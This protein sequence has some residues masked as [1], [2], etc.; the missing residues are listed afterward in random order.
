MFPSDADTK[1]YRR[2]VARLTKQKNDYEAR[3]A[4]VRDVEQLTRFVLEEA[5]ARYRRGERKINLRI[6]V[7]VVN[8]VDWARANRVIAADEN[9]KFT[10]QL[11]RS[12][13]L[14]PVRASFRQEFGPNLLSGFECKAGVGPNFV[15][16]VQ[17]SVLKPR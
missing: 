5:R 13:L 11:I 14:R 2:A 12:A 6:V 8:F 1:A 4:E 16:E 7:P 10:P 17:I 3:A 9:D 15:F